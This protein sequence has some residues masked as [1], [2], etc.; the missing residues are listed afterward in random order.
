MAIPV[1]QGVIFPR[2]EDA[3]EAFVGAG[4][5]SHLYVAPAN[6]AASDQNPGNDPAAPLATLAGALS[7]VQGLVR[8]QLA[9]I[10][11]LASATYDWNVTLSAIALSKPLCI[12]GDG[13]GQPGDDGFVVLRATAAAAAGTGQRAVVDPVGGLTVNGLVGKT[14]EILTGAAAGDRRSI[15]S[16]T[17]TTIIPDAAF[18]AAVAAGDTFRVVEPAV[19]IN[20]IMGTALAAMPPMIS[21]VGTPN[22]VTGIGSNTLAGFSTAQLL[23]A[24]LRFRRNPADVNSSSFIVLDSGVALAGVEFAADLP[25]GSSDDAAITAGIDLT[26]VTSPFSLFV[27]PASI[28]LAPNNTAWLGWGCRADNLA[29]QFKRLQGYL[30]V[31]CSTGT[32]VIV[33]GCT[34]NL[35][36][37]SIV[38]A[39]ASNFNGLV[40]AEQSR[41]VFRALDSLLPFLISAVGADNRACCLRAICGS[42]VSFIGL[43]AI[44]TGAGVALVASGSEITTNPEL[45]AGIISINF[46]ISLTAPY[47]G[48]CAM[49]GGRVYYDE[50][51]TVAGTMTAGQ[52][53]ITQS[54]SGGAAVVA[55]T[56]AALA[57]G[58]VIAN[59]DLSGTII[60]RIT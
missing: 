12:I 3:Q 21:G 44:I 1:N 33:R 9:V 39:N 43:E 31:F 23:L 34:W 16:N 42:I 10:I 2:R 7:R 25:A 29:P 52:A 32:T 4:A 18:T 54:S 28:G 26:G 59:P 60:G 5:T 41:L 14:V 55:S 22:N 40:R 8:S 50:D 51:P 36:G 58:A 15:R 38:S 13:A 35:A 6:A 48:V 57:D 47:A 20:N 45:E 37:G 46:V 11:H 24:N 30:N 49:T 27:L 56:F 53:I 17:A 19:V